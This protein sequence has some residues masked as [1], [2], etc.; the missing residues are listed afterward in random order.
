MDVVLAGVFGLLGCWPDQ[1]RFR[2]GAAA[3]RD[4]VGPDGGK[5]APRPAD[6]ARRWTVFATRPLSAV[7]L[8]AV[9]AGAGGIAFAAQKRRGV[10]VSR[11]DMRRAH[12]QVWFVG[13]AV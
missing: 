10:R 3:A 8:I 7:L 12:P 5:P 4:G 11:V 9:P 1:A 2:A 6:L 13:G